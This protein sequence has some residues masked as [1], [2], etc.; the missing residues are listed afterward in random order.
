MERQPERRNSRQ[1]RVT[2]GNGV[3]AE[4]GTSGLA[5]QNGVGHCDLGGW[6]EETLLVGRQSADSAAS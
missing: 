6:P 5:N 3:C 1:G 4:T 2:H